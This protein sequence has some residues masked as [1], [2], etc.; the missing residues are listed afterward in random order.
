[1]SIAS[2]FI[3]NEFRQQ[4]RVYVYIR[5]VF[6]N[7]T[8]YEGKMHTKREVI[9]SLLLLSDLSYYST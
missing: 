3:S 9:A 7:T 8:N 4:E 1:M 5:S 6:E 2:P